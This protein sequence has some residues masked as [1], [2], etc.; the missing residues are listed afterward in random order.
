MS[1]FGTKAE[2]LERFK[3]LVK[4]ALVPDLYYFTVGDYEKSP[5]TIARTVL[6]RFQGQR[7]IVR[8]SAF[9]EDGAQLSLAG[10][11]RSVP[12]V[13]G[14]NVQAVRAA[15]EEVICA[16][17]GNPRD[18]VLV[19]PMLADVA[20]SGVLM[21]YDLQTGAPY[22]ILNYDDESGKTD[23]ITGGIGVNKTVVVHRD[24]QPAHV[25]SGRVAEL[26]AMAQELEGLCGD[27]PLDIEFARTRTGDLCLLQIRRITVQCN[28]N[29]AVR[30]Q[31]SDAIHRAAAF[32]FER[33]QP[34]PG[35]LGRKSVL[36]QMPDWNPAEI[37]GV[38]PRPLAVSLYRDLVTDAVWQQARGVMGYRTVPREHLMVLLAGRPY[39]DVRNSFNSF[40][41]AAVDAEIGE[42]LVNCWIERLCAHPE[43]H[44]K[45]EFEVAQTTLDFAFEH[46]FRERY[47]GVLSPMEFETYR[48]SLLNLTRANVNLPPDGSLMRAC[49]EVDKLKRPSHPVPHG[50]VPTLREVVGLLESCRSSG[51]LPFAVIARHAFIA[52]ALLR[53]AVSREALA[54]ERLEAFKRSLVT[55]AGELARDFDAVLSGRLEMSR[56]LERYGHLRPGAYDLLSLRYDQRPD[57]FR[58]TQRPPVPERPEVF[59]L[60]EAEQSRL[61]RL[62]AECGLDHIDPDGLLSYAELAVVN[63]EYS[64]FV[65]TRHLSDALE[66]IARWSESA[67][68]TRDDASYLTLSEITDTLS[69]PIL[70]NPEARLQEIVA[71]R[72][73]ETELN[74]AVR[75]GYLI[76]DARD[77]YVAPMHRSAPN[78]VTSQTIVGPPVLLD[79]RSAGGID[80]YNKIVCIENADPGFDWIF[81]RGI[82]GIVTRFGGAN[83]HMTI[84][85]AELALPAAIGVGDQTFDRLAHADRIEL[86]CADRIVRPANEWF[87]EEFRRASA[88][89]LPRAA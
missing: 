5:D 40:L 18:Q 68:L 7:L 71:R 35:L 42:R 8:S 85:C 84:R 38:N 3:P 17:S 36:G 41:P 39:I 73:E 53:S 76:R 13:D 31:V 54:P 46:A 82:A 32:F 86:N 45:V 60:T 15:V 16:Y 88:D 58:T 70:T 65:F 61:A 69:V 55:V 62:L 43:L 83:S 11:Y 80:L 79:S 66:G 63:R 67:G 34:Q 49:A 9:H 10:A 1:L 21:T 20:M 52:E 77:I 56:F 57:L 27:A 23:R 74:R 30:A 44:D 50:E 4:R 75:L 25:E 19:Q 33:S 14:G 37:I 51:T 87:P 12:D 29:R 89:S 64:K 2:T 81:T 22:Y 48:E 47:D 78:F 59:H 6:R 28:W 72:R 26:L 24:F